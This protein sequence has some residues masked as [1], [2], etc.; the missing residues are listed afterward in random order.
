MR[1]LGKELGEEKEEIFE[2]EAPKLV[3][4]PKKQVKFQGGLVSGRKGSSFN[5]VQSVP[6]FSA[7]LRKE[8]RKPLNMNG[9]GSIM[10]MTPPTSKSGF[11]TGVVSSSRGSKSESAGEKKKRVGGGGVLMARKSYASFDELRSFSS[12]TATAIN[13][14]GR[15]GRNGRVMRKS[16]SGLRQF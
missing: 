3:T 10:E 9:L 16:V 14:E 5:V 2:V 8:N 12:V 15:G 4:P 6:D 11:A 1:C 13:G 7:V